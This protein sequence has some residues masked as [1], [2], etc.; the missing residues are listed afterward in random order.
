MRFH[1]LLKGFQFDSHLRHHHQSHSTLSQHHHQQLNT[2]QY[3]SH[4]QQ[5]QFRFE[6]VKMYEYGIHQQL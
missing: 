5:K 3:Q 1:Q 2:R 6:Q 4:Q